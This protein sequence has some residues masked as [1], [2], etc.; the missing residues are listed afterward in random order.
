ME[1]LVSSLIYE[2]SCKHLISLEDKK[3][4][5]F[6]GA[7]PSMT[8]SMQQAW[9]KVHTEVLNKIITTS[10]GDNSLLQKLLDENKVQDSHW[11]WAKKYMA[12]SS[13]SDYIWFYLTVDSIVQACC[14]IYH[15]EVSRFDSKNIFYVDYLAI[16]P[17][18]RNSILGVRKF[19]S[20]GTLL[21]AFATNYSASKL[22][23][24]HGFSLH[25]LPQA[26]K[27]YTEKL[28]MTSFGNDAKKEN[29]LF[30]EIEEQKA[31]EMVASY[32]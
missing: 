5:I 3:F 25:S 2:G 9:E 26:E 24:R 1:G 8:I 28:G 17:W 12:L 29:L 15:P 11:N 4:N 6:V 20:F 27:F 31:K 7:D 23:Y 19:S 18:N 16:A 10:N 32:V 22:A 13:S 21:L 30:L 14:I